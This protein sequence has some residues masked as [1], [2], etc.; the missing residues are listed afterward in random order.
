MLLSLRDVLVRFTDE[1]VLDRV[2]LT[3]QED[4][5]LC[6]AGRNGA[7]KSTL[8]RV[9]AGQI[10]PDEG[11]IVRRDNLKVALLDQ[12]VPPDTGGAVYEIVTRGLGVTGRRLLDYDRAAQHG[13]DS[14]ELLRLQHALEEAGAWNTHAEVDA[15]L[16][17]MELDP[18]ALFSTLSGGLRRRVMLA[19]A[20]VARPDVLLLDEPT[21]H[22]DIAGVTWLESIAASFP[23]A[24]VFITHDRAFLDR[25]ANR[26]VEVDR[27]R[28]HHFPGDFARYRRMKTGQLEQERQSN[29]EFDKRLA[30]EEEWIRRGVKART[31]RNMGRVRAL[32]DMR[33][34][35]AA[36]RKYQRRARMRTQASDP[37][38]HRVVELHRVNASI[39]GKTILRQFT[40][41]I[42][43]GDVIGVMGPNGSGKTTLLRLLLG[44]IEPESGTLKFGEN[45]EIAYF[46][47]T[48]RQL[49]LERSAAWNVADGA[50]RIE[51]DGKSLHVLGYLK[52]FLFTPQ[53]AQTR[54]RLLSG[55]ERNRLLLARLL[56]KPSNVLVLDEPTN[57]L[58]IETLELLEDLLNDYP[59]TIILVSHDRTFVDNVVDGLLV[60]EDGHGFRYYVGGYRDWVRQ[61]R[62]APPEV[63]TTPGKAPGKM[64]AGKTAGP[65]AGKLSYK[66]QRELDGLPRRIEETESALAALQQAMSEPDFFRQE[67]AVIKE[68][69]QRLAVLELEMETLFERWETLEETRARGD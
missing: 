14:H 24:L 3:I 46:D 62:E 17:R 10:A 26:I 47:Q 12:E 33:E 36:R 19:R 52:A 45:L 6:L 67:G 59:G 16:S 15:L 54:T 49:E 30:E 43:R 40:H 20:L 66:L 23:G 56:A 8:L 42:R 51:F 29:R 53:R 9:L 38:S 22:L 50:E 48:R 44:E 31:T 55:G 57:D 28:L 61:R 58:D 35:A 65:G 1:P 32:E 37:S 60:N 4:D 34:E 5:R 25:V 63:E 64:P 69:Q 21:N 27:G 39:A 13:A 68:A 2:D 11:E 41:K 7:G 18:R